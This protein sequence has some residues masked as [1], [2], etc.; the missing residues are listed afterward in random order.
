MERYCRD[1]VRSAVPQNE[2]YSLVNKTELLNGIQEVRADSE[3]IS[4]QKES[5]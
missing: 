2:A 5:Y 4:H 3:V 1:K